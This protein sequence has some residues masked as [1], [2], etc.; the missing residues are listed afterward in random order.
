MIVDL[1]KCRKFVVD[2]MRSW[3]M[4]LSVTEEYVNYCHQLLP[5]D[6]EIRDYLSP[7]ELGKHMP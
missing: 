3:T 7:V 1:Q 6:E 4:I 5:E 2:L